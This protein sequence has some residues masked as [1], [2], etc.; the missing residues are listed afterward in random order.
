MIEC[1]LT[2]SPAPISSSSRFTWTPAAICGD[3]WSNASKTLHVLWSNPLKQKNESEW[4]FD[5]CDF[6]SVY[7]S[8]YCNNMC[9]YLVPSTREY[10]TEIYR[11]LNLILSKCRRY[12]QLTCG[13]SDVT[14]RS[15]YIDAGEKTKHFR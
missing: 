3:C 8:T 15:T 5:D 2:W 4:F 11:L 10:S 9:R 13:C 1:V 14:R 7:F 6:F 12:T